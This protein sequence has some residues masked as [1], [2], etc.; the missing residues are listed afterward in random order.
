MVVLA[1]VVVACGSDDSDDSNPDGGSVA[2]VEAETCGDV[3][4][5]G[6]GDPEALIVSDLP[7]QGDS[8]DRSKQMNDAITQVLDEAGWTAGDLD[9]QPKLSASC[10]AVRF[11]P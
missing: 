9:I 4:F 11:A 3:Q 7:L 1:L 6:S 5:G 2:G 8:E 10:P